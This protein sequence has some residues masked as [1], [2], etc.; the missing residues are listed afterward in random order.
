MC[1]GSSFFFETYTKKKKSNQTLDFGSPTLL[2]SILFRRTTQISQ[3]NIDIWSISENSDGKRVQTQNG[4]NVKFNFVF[5][6][7]WCLLFI[8]L[9]DCFGLAFVW[10]WFEI[11]GST[12]CLQIFKNFSL[13]IFL[14]CCSCKLEHFF[15][16][17]CLS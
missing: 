2:N 9:K 13:R 16:T 11:R 15:F 6:F 5:F 3:F 4:L 1:A 10:F 7:F 12:N 17:F 14:R 8:H